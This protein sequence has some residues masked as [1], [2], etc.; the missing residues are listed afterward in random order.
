[1]IRPARLFSGCNRHSWILSNEHLS[2]TSLSTLNLIPFT[3]EHL[4]KNPSAP[5]RR[6]YKLRSRGPAILGADALDNRQEK[7][8]LEDHVFELHHI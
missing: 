6:D 1:V 5:I 7:I 4:G 8:V 2:L 3:I